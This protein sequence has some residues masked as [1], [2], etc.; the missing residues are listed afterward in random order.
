MHKIIKSNGD[1]IDGTDLRYTSPKNYTSYFE[2]ALSSNEWSSK[3]LDDGKGGYKYYQLNHPD[4]TEIKFHAY[5]KGVVW[6]SRN[7]HEKAA[8]MSGDLDM[9]GFKA[10]GSDEKTYA[11][12]IYRDPTQSGDP[13][14]EDDA[15][16]ICAWIPDQW[17]A[18]HGVK[19]FNYF[20]NTELISQAFK[21]GFAQAES[22][23]RIVFAFKPEFLHYYLFH[24]NDLHSKGIG[25]SIPMKLAQ[26]TTSSRF[27]LNQILYGPPGTGKTYNT[28][29]KAVEIVSNRDISSK[30]WKE[31]KNEYDQY[32][33]SSR[34]RFVTFHQSYS[35][36]EFI[37]GIKPVVDQ[38]GNVTYEISEGIF[39]KLCEDAKGPQ[40]IKVGEG[41]N[42]ANGDQFKIIHADRSL[43]NLERANGAIVT[44]PTPLILEL[45]KYV[46]EEKLSL[47]NIQDRE[48]DGVHISDLLE[49]KYDKYIFGYNSIL[50]PFIEF[51]AEKPADKP[52]NYVLIID[53]INRGNISKIFGEIITLIED[54]KRLGMP[55]ELT[56]KLTYSGQKA[57]HSDF[58]VPSNVF[59]IGTMNSADRSIALIDTALRRR[60]TFYNYSAKSNLI[61]EEVEGIKLQKLLQTINQR[62]EFLL[63]TDHLLG[64]SYFI[65]ISSKNELARVFR[66]KIIPLLEEYFYGDYEK[67]QLVLGDNPEYGKNKDLKI[68]TESNPS[69]QRKLFGTDLDGFED[70]VIYS[71]RPD[72]LDEDFESVP[73]NVFA[74]IYGDLIAEAEKAEE[75]I[76]EE[77]RVEE[78]A[79]AGQEED[80]DQNE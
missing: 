32:I 75:E 3:E 20:V 80:T 49:T 77:P 2:K 62:I 23:E 11:F 50:K 64:H 27:P 1:I 52:G 68:I 17:G 78:A 57:G 39:K 21:I 19:S 72:I 47:Q 60:F 38:N 58:G 51:L 6:R 13:Q 43:V 35:Y 66:N 41:F 33:D 14:N 69:T 8:Q 45:L 59:I 26:A 48:K 61:P 18:N 12:G 31:I 30:G 79:K 22:E 34:I 7:V 28:I 4:G 65:N 15:Y 44:F 5:V 73:F 76:I 24:R 70:K 67:I 53:E 37:E 71:L 40:L 63:D 10:I 74:S 56:A 46:Q 25:L 9:R 36:E 55:E 29:K 16:V 42:N 54:S